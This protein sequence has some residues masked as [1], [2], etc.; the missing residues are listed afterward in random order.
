MTP[1]ELN[2]YAEAFARRQKAEERRAQAYI[3]ALA[4]LIRPMVWA[5]HPPGFEKVFPERAEPAKEMSDDQ[6]YAKIRALNALFGG[7]EE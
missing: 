5:K 2:L 7:T 4:A 3:Y 6:L 1:A